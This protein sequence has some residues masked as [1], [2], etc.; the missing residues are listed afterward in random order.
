MPP[1][2]GLRRPAA[3]GPVPGAKAKPGARPRVRRR[4]GAALAGV[5]REEAPVEKF[6]R[7]EA[8]EAAQVPVDRWK[9]H[10]LVVF[11]QA[12]YYGKEISAAGRFKDLVLTDGNVNLRVILSGTTSEELL[13]H[14][15]AV[16]VRETTVHCCPEGCGNTPEGPLLLH[17]RHVRRVKAEDEGSLTW[18]KNMEVIITPGQVDEVEALRRKEE[19]LRKAEEKAGIKDKKKKKRKKEKDSEKKKELSEETDSGSEESTK[20]RKYGGRTVAKKKLDQ[21]YG[22]TGLDPKA[23]V[24]RK[25]VKLV[26]RRIKRRSRSSSSSSS[27]DSSGSQASV[28]ESDLMGDSSRLRLIARYGPGILTSSALATMRQSLADLDG[29]WIEEGNLHVP[30]TLRYVRSSMASKISGGALRESMALGTIIDMGLQGRI[31]ELMDVA[32]QRLKSIEAVGGGATWATGEKLELLPG[33]TPQIRSRGEMASVNRELKLDLQAQPRAP[34]TGGQGKGW[35][36]ANKGKTKGK[37]EE[38]GGKGKKK[39]FEGGKKKEE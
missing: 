3:A 28:H 34:S 23:K 6:L 39:G 12:I 5:G 21:V 19:E 26:Q 37:A 8:I 14:G 30:I 13:K 16:D 31:S 24:R 33:L 1:K 29:A 20:K 7:G 22:G 11:D 25:I 18:E 27:S 2:G 35:S 36:N 38:K 9:K 10:E 17:S 15:T 4:P 32:V